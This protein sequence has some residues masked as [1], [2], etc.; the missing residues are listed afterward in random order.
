EAPPKPK[1][2]EQISAADLKKYKP[3][4]AGAIPVI[5]YHR[6]VATEKINYLNRPPALFRNDLENMKA[7]GYW[8]V[9]AWDVIANK[10]DVPLGKSPI[11]LTV[12]DALPSQFHIAVKNGEDKIDPDCAIGILT[13]FQKS[14]GWPAK[15][16]FFV[17]PKYGKNTDP[18]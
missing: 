10:M 17:L 18:F 16:T 2:P 11:V 4:E 3:N 1:A 14:S 8:P 5:M 15:A 7:R 12:D 9:N 6:F 13:T